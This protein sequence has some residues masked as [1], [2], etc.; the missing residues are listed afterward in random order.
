[1]SV[2]AAE[3]IKPLRQTIPPQGHRVESRRQ[4]GG[5]P[6]GEQQGRT[7]EPSSVWVVRSNVWNFHHRSRARTCTGAIL[8]LLVTTCRKTDE[9]PGSSKNSKVVPN[10]SSAVAAPFPADGGDLKC[11]LGTDHGRI[12]IQFG[13]RG[14]FGGSDND[15]DLDVSSTAF[16]SG[17]RWTGLSTNDS[18]DRVALDRETGQGYLRRLVSAFL[19]QDEG[20]NGWSTTK[21]FVRVS[22]S[23]GG[24]RSGPFM[25]ETDTTSPEE[26]VAFDEV[27]SRNSLPV[28]VRRH[29]YSRVHGVIAVAKAILAS[30]PNTPVNS[31]EQLETARQ[32]RDSLYE[33]GIRVRHDP[34][35]RW[36]DP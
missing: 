11:L 16:L 24:V 15:L 17:H 23:C 10:E 14:C 36:N 31:M 5:E 4:L 27:F 32:R 2:E 25:I 13:Y 28:P 29:V 7:L 8:F 6:A 34:V 18:T 20:A 22:Y 3:P 12:H 21:A 35:E 9:P 19:K 26:E 30:V 1:V 33:N